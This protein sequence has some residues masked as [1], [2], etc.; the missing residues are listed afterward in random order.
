MADPIELIAKTI[1]PVPFEGQEPWYV[2]M[3][4]ARNL[5][6][7]RARRIVDVLR[8]HGWVIADAELSPVEIARVVAENLEP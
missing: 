4:V 6:R 7:A 3:H 5:A 8:S 1:D 2:F